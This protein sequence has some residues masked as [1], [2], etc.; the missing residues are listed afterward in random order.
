MA[1]RDSSPSDNSLNRSTNQ[2]K[3]NFKAEEKR[4]KK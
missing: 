1:L 4:A 3:T 2:T